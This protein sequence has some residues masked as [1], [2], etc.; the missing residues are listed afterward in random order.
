MTLLT[1]SAPLVAVDGDALMHRAYHATPPATGVDGHPVAALGTFVGMLAALVDAYA[2]R[3][4]AVALDCRTPGYR[5]ALWPAYQAQRAPFDADIVWQLDALPDLLAPFGIAVAKEA[6][7]EADDLLAAWAT[8]EEAADGRCLVVTHDRD[9]Y[10]L[11]SEAVHVV[12]P[13]KGVREVELVDRAGVV[14]RYGVLPEQVPD[15][16]ALRGGPVRQPAR[17]RRHRREDGG[18]APARARRPRGA[19]SPRRPA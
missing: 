9:A 5:N 1:A 14:S 3:A 7:H 4:I 16:I 6:P 18:R 19:C 2:P 11:V 15:L 13:V 10:Q 12:R 17:R 8:H